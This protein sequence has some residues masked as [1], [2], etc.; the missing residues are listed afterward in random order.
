MFKLYIYIIVVLIM[1]KLYIV[2]QLF[3]FKY[4]ITMEIRFEGLAD[5]YKIRFR[6]A[7]LCLF[8]LFSN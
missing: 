3:Y 2:D 8:L 7:V 1:Y 4:S 5:I 6:P